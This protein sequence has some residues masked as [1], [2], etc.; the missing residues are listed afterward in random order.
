MD[1][2]GRGYVRLWRKIRHTEIW[3]DSRAVHV[4]T[5]CL[6]KANHATD[7][8]TRGLDRGQLRCGAIWA[9]EELGMSVSA[10]RR[11]LIRLENA[12]MITREANS[13]RTTITVV[14]YKIYNTTKEEGEQPAN[15]DRTAPEQPANTL[16][17]PKNPRTQE[18]K[19][20]IKKTSSLSKPRAILTA[21]EFF[22]RW[23]SFAKGNGLKTVIKLTDERREKLRLRLVD[24]DW[25]AT[26]Q[27]AVRMLP[28]AGEGWQ[29]DFDWMIR[30]NQNVYLI[31]EGKYAWRAKNDPAVAKLEEQKRKNAATER[32]ERIEQQK[33]EEKRSR[34][35]TRKTIAA[36]LNQTPG[37]DGAE[38]DADWLFGEEGGCSSAN[39]AAN[40]ATAKATA[41][42]PDES[43]R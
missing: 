25:W 23:N 40:G 21:Q 42:G 24:A 34:S 13:Q 27:T 6:V 19:K 28:L 8:P 31:V 35:A 32:I 15:I 7:S 26:F 14:N 39:G 33:A 30:N 2:E 10:F 36:T 11:A 43:G 5:F 29:P 12:G 9:S 22:D 18:P 4:W 37:S 3:N 20:E 1:D 17:E 16:E 38:Q 41:Q